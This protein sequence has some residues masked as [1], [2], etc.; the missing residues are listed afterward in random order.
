MSKFFHDADDDSAMTLPGL[1][2]GNSRAQ[3]DSLRNMVKRH[4]DVLKRLYCAKDT[5]AQIKSR[6]FR[7]KSHLPDRLDFTCQYFSTE[8]HRIAKIFQNKIN[9]LQTHI[10]LASSGTDVN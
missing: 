2:F 4:G 9:R 8:K 5:A 3:S 10:Y 7:K 1:S 6:A